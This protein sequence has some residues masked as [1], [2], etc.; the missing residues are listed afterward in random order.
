M[1][2]KTLA[3]TTRPR[4]G[5]RGAKKAKIPTVLVPRDVTPPFPATVSG[6]VVRAKAIIETVVVAHDQRDAHELQPEISWPL[7][8]A[9]EM[10][11]E[12]LNQLDRE[13][14]QARQVGGA[15]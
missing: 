5:K 8:V 4:A 10:L 15:S 11:T 3:K 13:Q 7:E 2:K 14:T 1:A 12:A 9:A 6:K